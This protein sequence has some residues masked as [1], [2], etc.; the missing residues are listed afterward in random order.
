MT[1]QLKGVVINYRFGVITK[2]RATEAGRRII[3][4]EFKTLLRM[5][6]DRVRW[7]IRKV[8]ELPPEAQRRLER[9]RDEYVQDFLKILDDV[10]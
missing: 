9:W 1:R 7:T 2:Q 4:D 3:E 8:G 5:S 6:R 10:K